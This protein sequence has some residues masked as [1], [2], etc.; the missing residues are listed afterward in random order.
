MR[1]LK[2]ARV[3]Q[4][5]LG[6]AR[7]RQDGSTRCAGGRGGQDLAGA[8]E[9]PW[10]VTAGA[11]TPGR[12]YPWSRVGPCCAVMSVKFK[13]PD[14]S[15]SQRFR[16]QTC[17]DFS[18]PT[19]WTS[20]GCPTTQFGSDVSHPGQGQTPHVKRPVPRV[21]P[22]FTCQRQVRSQAATLPPGSC[23]FGGS[24]DALLRVRNLPE[25]LTELRKA[26]HLQSVA[27]YESIRVRDSPAGGRPRA[28]R[29]VGWRRAQ[30]TR[31]HTRCSPTRKLADRHLGGV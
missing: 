6:T 25:Q 3:A 23:R 19:H 18:A 27:A 11:G 4:R 12:W 21:C 9:R 17:G 20:K 29:G 16:P 26:P 28:R 14:C 31:P 1:R 22:R 10:Q 7:G 13:G 24:R 5:R 2:E 30:G 8:L 15:C